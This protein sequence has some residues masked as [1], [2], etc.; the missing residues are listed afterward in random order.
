MVSIIKATMKAKKANYAF[1]ILY[2]NLLN[3]FG[4][5]NPLITIQFKVLNLIIHFFFTLMQRAHD[6]KG[7]IDCN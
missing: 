1:H 7:S 2:L 3:A 6:V 5:A 4:K